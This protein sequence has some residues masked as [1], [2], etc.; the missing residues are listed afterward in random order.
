MPTTPAETLQS[1]NSWRTADLIA[2]IPTDRTA[3]LRS[4]VRCID[5]QPLF[6][7]TFSSPDGVTGIPVVGLG[8]SRALQIVLESPAASSRST[9]DIDTWATSF[10]DASQHLARAELV[11]THTETG[12]LRLIADN[13]G[14]IE[15][16]IA[17]GNPPLRW[18]ERADEAWWATWSETR[19]PVPES[20]PLDRATALIEQRSLRY[21]LPING[22]IAGVDLTLARRILAEL[23]VIAAGDRSGVLDRDRLVQRLAECSGA[24]PTE[25]SA[26]LDAVTLD[27]TNAAWH[28]AV[29]GIT[30]PPLISLP[31]GNLVVSRR[32]TSCDPFRFLTRELRRRDPASYHSTAAG[33]ETSFRADLYRLF[34]HRRFVTASGPIELRRE[35]GSIRTDIDAAIF[36]RKTGTLAL[37]ELKTNEPFA[38]ST[39]E[40]LRTV[41]NTRAA[42]RQVANILDWINRHGADEILN[43]I[44]RQAARSFR[45]Q[46]VQAFVLGRHL[47]EGTEKRAVWATW[48]QLLRVLGNDAVTNLGGNPIATL[49]ARLARNQPLVSPRAVREPLVIDLGDLRLRVS[50]LRPT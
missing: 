24:N 33:R 31:D 36:D 4:L 1:A 35:Q 23:V 44:D 16:S 8:N 50:P 7:P 15:A 42:G 17:Q 29:P 11:L 26:T 21:D 6:P 19:F 5:D 12:F 48:P 2:T 37:F 40:L 22:I 49:A 20:P 30:D 3:A 43:R 27:P 10:L 14:R 25:V 13:L 38:R 9:P 18:R 28:A 46:K 41:E 32:G 34:S 45:V 47:V 39:A